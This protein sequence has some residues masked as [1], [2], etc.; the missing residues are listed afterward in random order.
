MVDKEK[1]KANNN[2]KNELPSFPTRKRK[3]SINKEGKYFFS[4][5]EG[6]NIAVDMGGT[7]SKLS[8]YIK[9]ELYEKFKDLI[10]SISPNK[11]MKII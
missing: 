2:S 9:N 7:L 11:T 8:I 1:E 4:S 6:V 3:S 10:N 5:E